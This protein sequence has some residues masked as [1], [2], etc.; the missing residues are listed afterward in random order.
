MK[1]FASR[2]GPSGRVAQLSNDMCGVELGVVAVEVAASSLANISFASLHL[3]APVAGHQ[4]FTYGHFVRCL[5]ELCSP[6]LDPHLSQNLESRA[7]LREASGTHARSTTSLLLMLVTCAS[8][9]PISLSSIVGHDSA[10][11]T[12]DIIWQ[13]RDRVYSWLVCDYAMSH[14]QLM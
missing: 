14:G 6:W 8:T 4:L 1:L 3:R 9:L 10:K 13:S 12:S 5:E 7:A 2:T 11:F